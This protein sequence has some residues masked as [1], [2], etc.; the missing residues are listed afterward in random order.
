M[1]PCPS[2]YAFSC[3]TFD[4]AVAVGEG[5]ATPPSRLRLR[6]DGFFSQPFIQSLLI[7]IDIGAARLWIEKRIGLRLMLETGEFDVPAGWAGVRRQQEIARQNAQRLE[8]AAEACRGVG[9]VGEERSAARRGGKGGVRT[10][11]SRW[12]PYHSQKKINTPVN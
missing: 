2:C 9:L 5:L 6:R 12:S 10:C 7:S 11:R 4:K 3:R 8:C 1:A